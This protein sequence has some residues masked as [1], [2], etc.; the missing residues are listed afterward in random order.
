MPGEAGVPGE[1][2]SCNVVVHVATAHLLALDD[3]DALAHR[4]EVGGEVVGR[5]EFV[6]DLTLP[7]VGTRSP[8]LGRCP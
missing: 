7:L 6:L 5:L 4:T 2:V 3:E 8:A 1:G